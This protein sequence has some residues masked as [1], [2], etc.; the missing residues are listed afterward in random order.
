MTLSQ[1]RTVDF[2]PWLF[3]PRRD[4]AVFGLSAALPLGLVAARRASGGAPELPEWAWLVFVLGIDVGH[5]YSTLFRTYLDGDELRR[6]RT[7]YVAAPLAAYAIGV[8]LYAMGPLLFW[9]VLAY[10]AL[11]HFVRQQVGWAAVYRAREGRR[12]RVDAVIDSAALY[13]ATL[14]PVFVWHADPAGRPFSWFIE[15]D[16]VLSP[17]L[18]PWEPLAFALWVGALGAFALRQI[19]RAATERLFPLGR[20]VVV[21]GTASIWYVG[22]VASTSDFDFTVTNVVAHGVPYVALLYAYASA[23]RKV[24]KGSAAGAIAGAGI[25]AFV[26]ML[27]VL[28]FVEELAWDRLVWSERPWLFGGGGPPLTAALM[29]AIVPLLALPQATHYVLDGML[30]RRSDTRQNRAQRVALGFEP[31]AAMPGGLESHPRGR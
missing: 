25:G 8:V 3:G 13:L 23:R 2:G 4:L 21:I 9:R 30:W 28:A 22:I 27:L 11:F 19:Q 15:G 18:A 10:V 14:Y 5:V 20:V 17:A 24:R 16:F 12:H 6:H 29:A 31:E 1:A 26:T 7:R